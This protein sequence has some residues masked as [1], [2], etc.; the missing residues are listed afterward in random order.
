MNRT[1]IQ[2]GGGLDQLVSRYKP[3]LLEEPSPLVSEQATAERSQ[4]RAT[5]NYWW[6]KFRNLHNISTPDLWTILSQYP[7][8]V[9]PATEINQFFQLCQIKDRPVLGSDVGL[10]ITELIRRSYASG[11][12]DFH[13]VAS[14]VVS[15][16]LRPA[17]L[18]YRLKAN[19]GNPLYL[20][21]GG[22]VGYYC[23]AR[24]E[25]LVITVTG[26]VLIPVG[27]TQGEDSV[28][29]K[30]GR[31]RDDGEAKYCTFRFYDSRTIA[32][33]KRTIPR[34]NA[35]VWVHDDGRETA[36]RRMDQ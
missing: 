10:F 6:D 33:I 36:V 5:L 2:K 29:L 31:S 12:N 28:F 13:F 16:E 14:T 4:E 35:I 20:T 34:G 17:W 25:H 9:L 27:Q 22:D 3:S 15:P 21:V 23:A 24:G 18:G 11:Q 32:S 30:Q 1:M 8:P 7:L 19:A 26:T